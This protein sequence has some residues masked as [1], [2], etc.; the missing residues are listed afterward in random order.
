MPAQDGSPLSPGPSA[1]ASLTDDG[2]REE[3][4]LL[5]QL[6]HAFLERGF[7]RLKG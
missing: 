2:K 7:R 1:D 5:P 6:V 4:Q 3:C